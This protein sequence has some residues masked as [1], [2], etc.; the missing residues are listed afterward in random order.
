MLKLGSLVLGGKAPRVAVPF[1]GA[2][3][4]EVEKARRA[5][6]DIA[7]ARIDRC[8]SWETK[9]VLRELALLRKMPLI[10]TIR[11]KKEG[12]GWNRPEAA[13][14]KLFEAVLPYVD[15]IDIELAAGETLKKIGRLAKKK[16][17]LLIVSHHDFK[18]TPKP[19]VLKKIVR[20]AEAAGADIV[21]IAAQV[22][23]AGHLEDLAALLARHARKNL[24]IIGMGEQGIITRILFPRM[25][26]LITYAHW[27]K[28]SGAPGQLPYAEMKKM[29]EQ[30]YPAYGKKRRA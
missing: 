24:I 18:T 25:G 7:E 21:K 8:A 19:A 6:V 27:G 10:A 28:K 9:T 20:H 5:G 1:S 23:N 4:A 2:S 13:R 16:G 11:I 29:L 15:A 12:G 22:K 3:A 17:K 30:L 26:S 14:R